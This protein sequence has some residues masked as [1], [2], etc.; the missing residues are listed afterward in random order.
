MTSPRHRPATHPSGRSA[1]PLREFGDPVAAPKPSPDFIP[2]PLTN[3]TNLVLP[4]HAVMPDDWIVSAGKIVF[5]M[6]G[7]T[8]GINDANAVQDQ[9]A[10][11]MQ[12][13]VAAAPKGSV[14]AF[15]YNLGDVVYFNGQ[16]Y[17]YRWQ[18][19]E[20]YQ[21]YTPYIFAIPGNHDGD[22]HARRNDPPVTEPSL[23]GFMRNFCDT[24]PTSLA[25][26]RQTMTQP[27]V[28]WTLD[29]PFVTVIGLYSNVDGSLDGRGTFEQ[30]GWLQDQLKQAAQDKCLLVAVHHPPYSLDRPHGGSPDILN[31]LDR[32]AQATGRVP[33][34]VFSGHV[35]SYQRFTRT[36]GG[37]EVPYVVAGAG[38]YAH[39]PKA[40]HKLQVNPADKSPIQTPFQTIDPEVA[41][42]AYNDTGP[43][44]LRVTIDKHTL[45]GEYFL[46]PF[47][48]DPPADAADTFTV[49]LKKHKV[50]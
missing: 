7:D 8:G 31:A 3:N 42:A 9:V 4:L 18:F 19:Y 48:G 47:D 13:Q 20:P 38:G 17:Y 27:Y 49:D 22:T 23:T 16:S 35:H 39:I 15:F 26:Y 24:Q 28:Y 6:V 2:P 21:S 5:H 41:L 33:D 50:K 30:Q 11:V 44:F 1:K 45:L 40:M 37:R 36:R 29:A 10:G 46:V 25:P 43:G 32:A 34:A 14:P 12:D